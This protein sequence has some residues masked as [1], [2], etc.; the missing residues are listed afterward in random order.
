LRKPGRLT[1]EEFEV[2]ERHPTTG[3]LVLSGVSFLKDVVPE[4]LH[5]HERLDGGGYPSGLVGDAI[6][7]EARVLAVADTYEALTSD[8]PYRRGFTADE[9]LSELR[10]SS[11]SQLDP[12]A[13]HA[14]EEVLARGNKFPAL[15]T[16][17]L[18]SG[19][20]TA[21]PVAHQA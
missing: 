13:V 21:L 6:P 14:L 15:P 2:V 9:A 17:S 4:V 20:S 19:G 12:V 11:G 8:R 3:A 1:D 18:E 10:R 7:F 16:R 5:H